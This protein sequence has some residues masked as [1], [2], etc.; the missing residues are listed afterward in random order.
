MTVGQ[1]IEVLKGWDP[2]LKVVDKNGVAVKGARLVV[3]DQGAKPKV[4][5]G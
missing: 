4:K 3:T 1:L 5:L 2:D